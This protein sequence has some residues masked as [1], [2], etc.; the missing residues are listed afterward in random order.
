MPLTHLATG[1]AAGA[2][3]GALAVRPLAFHYTAPTSHPLPRRTCPHCDHPLNATR[4]RD[5][6]AISLTRR[7]PHCTTRIGP[8]PLLP[9]ALAAVGFAAALHGGGGPWVTAAQLWLATIGAVLVITDASV[10]RL[11]DHLTAAAS[12][13][14]A[15]SLGAATA[16]GANGSPIRAAE[17]A[18]ITS[19]VFFMLL[20]AGG[21]SMGDLK[22]APPL[23]TVLGWHSWSSV[24]WGLVAAFTLGA[25]H[26]AVVLGNN[27]RQRRIA[28]GPALIIGTL[29]VTA[30]Y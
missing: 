6:R 1:A 12:V 23:A 15:L 13:G 9:E 14:T 16:S 10:R 24:F 4:P 8:A 20:L 28:F 22:V 30:I 25:A 17:A 18:A 11:P 21:L 7:C 3:T 26:A 19:A 2:L 27:M 29:A 5:L